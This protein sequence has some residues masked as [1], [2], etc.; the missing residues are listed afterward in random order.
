MTVKFVLSPADVPKTNH[1]VIMVF[2][3]YAHYGSNNDYKSI[4]LCKYIAVDTLEELSESI[5]SL[6]GKGANF[7]VLDQLSVLPYKVVV[8]YPTKNPLPKSEID[9][10]ED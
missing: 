4:D 1:Y 3:K 9:I 7:F 5:K 6:S 8:E 2:E 10:V